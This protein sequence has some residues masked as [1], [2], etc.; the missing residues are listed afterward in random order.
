MAGIQTGLNIKISQTCY[1]KISQLKSP[2]HEVLLSKPINLGLLF[3]YVLVRKLSIRSNAVKRSPF[4][5]PRKNLA[6][7]PHLL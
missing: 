6:V 2:K 3:F 7:M 1:Q 4:N 5:R